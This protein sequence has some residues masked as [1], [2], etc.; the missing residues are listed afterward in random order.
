M[1]GTHTCAHVSDDVLHV[2]V[3]GFV[4][5]AK[6]TAGTRKLEK[7]FGWVRETSYTSRGWE[8]E[9]RL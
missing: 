2:S 5:S 4:L 1:G 3:L 9:W 8:R 6:K 7:L